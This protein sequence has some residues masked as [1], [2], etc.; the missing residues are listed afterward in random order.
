MPPSERDIQREG[1]ERLR[2]RWR[3][4]YAPALRSKGYC[5]TNE[6]LSCIRYTELLASAPEEKQT[7][8]ANAYAMGDRSG[9]PD[10]LVFLPGGHVVMMEVKSE[11][12]RLSKKQDRCVARLREMGHEV[13]I[14]RS[15]ADMVR[16]MNDIVAKMP[17]APDDPR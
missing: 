15:I 11:K 10:L 16:A 3:D 7:I 17:E 6:M 5:V 1:V 4:F 2:Q 13:L 14:V 9:V 8:I 12:G